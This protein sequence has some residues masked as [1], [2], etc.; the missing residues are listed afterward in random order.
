[1]LVAGVRCAQDRDAKLVR[2]RAELAKVIKK[3]AVKLPADKPVMELGAD[4]L[5]VVEWVMA[6]EDAFHVPI[7]DDKI[8]DAK[9][10]MIRKEVSITYVVRLVMDGLEGARKK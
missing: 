2:V 3:D 9:S 7:P 5:D 1:L 10:K 8:I 6:V 4:D